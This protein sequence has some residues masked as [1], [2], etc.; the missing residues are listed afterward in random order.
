LKTKSS[1]SLL[2]IFAIGEYF[3]RANQRTVHIRVED[4]AKQEKFLTRFTVNLLTDV[5]VFVGLDVV[6]SQKQ[7]LL[8]AIVGPNT[9]LGTCL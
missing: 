4:I 9:Y 8:S 2:N 7:D 3:A 1:V 6:K 5:N